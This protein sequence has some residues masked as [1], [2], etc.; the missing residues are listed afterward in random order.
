MKKIKILSLLLMVFALASCG[1]GH[2]PTSEPSEEP[3]TS[4]SESIEESS[5][6]T[7]DDKVV[8]V[9]FYADYNRVN[10][11]KPLLDFMWYPGQL[12]PEEMI[13][14]MDE[15]EAPHGYPVFAGWS[16][17]TLIDDLNDLWDF[18]TDK[19]PTGVYS[20]DLFG[21]WFAEGELD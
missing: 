14:N 5:E 19:V 2:K 12:I 4:E 11:S 20:L 1:K 18:R 13:P 8:Y 9:C 17:H 10:L 3:T 7:E 16:T 15:V 21:I 6:L